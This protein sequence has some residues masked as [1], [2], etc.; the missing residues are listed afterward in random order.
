MIK[1]ILK[2]LKILS[3]LIITFI[4]CVLFFCYCAYVINNKSILHTKS[5]LLQY[6]PDYVIPFISIDINNT[7]DT[8]Y[9]KLNYPL[10]F[11]PDFCSNFADKVELIKSSEQ[12]KKYV[13][14][15]LDNKIII[16][17][18]HSGPYEATI[19]YTKH[20]I[21]EK[22]NIIFAE[23][24]NPHLKDNKD[25]WLWK[26]SISNFHGLYC[27]H[28]PEMETYK[29]KK[30]IFELTNRIPGFY[31]GRYDIRY[32]D[33]NAVKNGNG[34]KIIELN[35]TEAQDTRFDLIKNKPAFNIYII[36]SRI[37]NI[38]YYGIL[39]I[40]RLD[41]GNFKDFMKYLK[42][43]KDKANKCNHTEKY[44]NIMRKVIGIFNTNLYYL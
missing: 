20:P 13:N 4:V 23:R 43:K 40:L 10:I 11:K 39:K 19:Y 26:S 15:S 7:E 44:K 21:T 41:V 3:I 8:F 22:E 1:I 37:V 25:A 29:L 34:F 33:I 36:I 28:R 9:D 24:V 16:Q 31:I 38:Y 17:E 5:D 27:I 30:K 14:D 42:D 12:A 32:S 2:I 6:F 18:Y 35:Q